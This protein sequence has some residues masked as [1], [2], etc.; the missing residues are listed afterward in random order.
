MFTR[1]RPLFRERRCIIHFILKINLLQVLTP[2]QKIVNYFQLTIDYRDLF[3]TNFH[4]KISPL[5]TTLSNISG[6]PVT[7]LKIPRLVYNLPKFT[8]FETK[9]AS[10]FVGG[11]YVVWEKHWWVSRKYF[12]RLIGVLFCEY[13]S[14]I[15][16]MNNNRRTFAIHEPKL[17]ILRQD[18]YNTKTSIP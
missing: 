5:F 2:R 7:I 1:F 11:F 16:I 6:R 4:D 9:K 13:Y 10:K 12:L 3:R 8:T 15:S 17:T 18:S 14:K